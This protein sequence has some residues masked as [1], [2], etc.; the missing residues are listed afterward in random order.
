MPQNFLAALTL[1][2][3]I[4]RVGWQERLSKDHTVVEVVKGIQSQ[5]ERHAPPKEGGADLFSGD[6]AFTGMHGS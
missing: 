6:V 2:E 3:E 1:L 5:L 4:G